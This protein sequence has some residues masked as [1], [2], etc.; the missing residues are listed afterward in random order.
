MMGEENTLIENTICRTGITKILC[1][2]YQSYFLTGT[3][4]IIFGHWAFGKN[5]SLYSVHYE[6]IGTQMRP[7]IVFFVAPM[8]TQL[9][10]QGRMTV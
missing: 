3:F 8:L 4:R 5:L 2:I 1:K 9:H 6:L 7:L 10:V